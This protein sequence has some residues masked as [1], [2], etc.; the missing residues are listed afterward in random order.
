MCVCVCVFIYI[1]MCVCVCVYISSLL[2][3]IPLR[4]PQNPVRGWQVLVGHLFCTQSCTNV[5]PDLPVHSTA[6]SHT[7]I[8][9][10]N[11][12]HLCLYFCLANEC[13]DIT[14]LYSTHKRYYIQHLFFSLTHF[15]LY[16]SL[17]PST[18][19]QIA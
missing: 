4:S 6:P 5:D 19:L 12:L 13:I 16:E 1:Y 8:R 3:F 10:F 11:S 15:T 9:T 2:D 7:G 17:G 14:F 18:P